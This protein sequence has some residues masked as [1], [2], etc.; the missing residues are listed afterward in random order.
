MIISSI[1]DK[2]TR[3]ERHGSKADKCDTVIVINILACRKIVDDYQFQC[4]CN[5]N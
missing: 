4:F 1:R 3:E 5:N 2:N